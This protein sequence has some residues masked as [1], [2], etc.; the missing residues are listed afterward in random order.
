[1]RSTLVFRAWKTWM[2]FR[3][4]TLSALL[5]QDQELSGGGKGQPKAF[6][7]LK[8][9]WTLMAATITMQARYCPS[10]QA[11]V[12]ALVRSE[13]R[14]HDCCIETVEGILTWQQGKSL[15]AWNCA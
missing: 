11:L 10:A 3:S 14:F 6:I 2:T 13:Q 15:R 5:L 7:S 9:G 4:P 1:M 8:G 12:D